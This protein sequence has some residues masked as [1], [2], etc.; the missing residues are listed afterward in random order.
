[1]IWILRKATIGCFIFL[2]SSFCAIQKVNAQYTDILAGKVISK[3]SGKPLPYANVM[4]RPINKGL[5]SDEQGKF[6]IAIPNHIQTDTFKLSLSYVGMRALDTLIVGPWKGN[7]I[8]ALEEENLRLKEITTTATRL[9]DN[10]SSSV[11]EIK[12]QAISQM[13]GNS[14]TEIFQTLPGGKILNP[15]FQSLKTFNLRTASESETDLQNNAFGI[16]FFVDGMQLSNDV[17][18]QSRNPGIPGAGPLSHP[19]GSFYSDRGNGDN[20]SNGFDLRQFPL[21][22]IESVQVIQGVPTAEYGNLTDGAVIIKTKTGKTPFRGRFSM[23]YGNTSAA[24]GKGFLLPGKWGT[25]NAS[26]TYLNSVPNKRNKIKSFNRLTGSLRWVSFLADKQ[27]RND[28]KVTIGRN[29]DQTKLDPDQGDDRKSKFEQTQIRIHEELAYLPSN[30]WVDKI[31]GSFSLSYEKQ[32]SYDQQ[33]LNSGVKAISTALESG[34]FEGEFIPGNYLSFRSIEGNPVTTTTALKIKKSFKTGSIDHLLGAGLEY[35]FSKNY[36]DGR[37]YDLRRPRFVFDRYGQERPYD[38]KDAPAQ[39]NFG[40]YIQ[41]A[42]S[43]RLGSRKWTLYAG[44]R[45]D[46]QNNWAT[47]SPRT[48][49]NIQVTKRIKLKTAFGMSSKAPSSEMLYPGPLYF[50]IP[51]LKYYPNDPDENLFLVHTKVFEARPKNLKVQR[52]T[53]MELTMEYNSS[54]GNLHITAFR[55][56]VDNGFQRLKK[57]VAYEL[58][59]YEIA[60]TPEGQKPIYQESGKTKIHALQYREATNG[61][62]SNNYGIELYYRSPKIPELHTSFTANFQYIKSNTFNDHG[63]IGLVPE[64]HYDK[65]IQYAYYDKPNTQYEKLG[66]Q[67]VTNHHFPQLGLSVNLRTELFL[68]NNTYNSAWDGT[69]LG[70]YTDSFEYIPIPKDEVDNPEYSYLKRVFSEASTDKLPFVYGNLHLRI[71]KEV[72]RNL[73]LSFRI[74]NLLN[75][76]PRY[77]YTD[78][79][80]KE[81]EEQLNQ[82]PFYGAEINYTF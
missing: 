26:L 56:R 42:M 66:G 6:Q 23:A 40:A 55:K 69:P 2:L 75:L 8:F 80:G 44:L 28:L 47:F 21:D 49:F 73:S 34:T 67:I 16:G 82:T 57:Y 25:L 58:P 72:N 11:I 59:V 13:Q 12:E 74:N 10:N 35:R 81:Y 65:P 18:M 37:V 61:R 64:E 63:E 7:I 5:I 38:F 15:E 50:D 52:A 4:I 33:Y 78:F 32:S 29:L 77:K 43:G 79:S 3:A 36:G 41:D 54:F 14:L 71:K 31:S 19:S 27:L 20:P 53:N 22:D 68:M 70:Y 76:R 1:M 62:H 45:I 60:D 30:N 51:L 39:K 24:L 46:A 17:N 48:T 9:S